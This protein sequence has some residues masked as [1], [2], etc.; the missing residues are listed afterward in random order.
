MNL[1]LEYLHHEIVLIQL[2]TVNALLDVNFSQFVPSTPL[3]SAACRVE[4]NQLSLN[5]VEI[6]KNELIFQLKHFNFNFISI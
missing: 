2:W 3:A 4:N 5:L 6:K 1:K